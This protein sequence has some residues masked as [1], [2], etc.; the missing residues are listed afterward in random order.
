MAHL[1]HLQPVVAAP[2]KILRIA[3]FFAKRI[4]WLAL[5]ALLTPA[6]AA[7]APEETFPVLKIGAQ[8]Y[9]NVTVTTKAKDYIFITHSSGMSNIK[10]NELS[11]EV[12]DQLG[13]RAAEEEAA[14]KASSKTVSA[15]AKNALAKV[16]TSRLKEVSAVLR[17]HNPAKLN[18]A[19]ASAIPVLIALGLGYLLFCY[20][21][22]LI[23]QKTGNEPGV[24]VWVPI[25]QFIPL[26]RAAGMSPGWI[27]ALLLPLLNVI[28]LIVWA[29]NIAAARN[30]SGW[31]ALFLILPVTN[32]FAFLYLAFS[33]GTPRRDSRTK[34]TRR[35]ELMTLETA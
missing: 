34:G 22:M 30:K 14:K 8:T 32:L 15:W 20:C 19:S 4:K 16:E 21:S 25:L 3:Q 11:A 27:I 9:Q 18:L 2:M 29:S 17:E 6:W 12:R 33:K 23:C 10:V 35:M 5:I 31:V 7:P 24:L 1:L 26:L 13:Y 28:G